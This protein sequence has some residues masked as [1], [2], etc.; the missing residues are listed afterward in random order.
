MQWYETEWEQAE[1]LRADI[2]AR[3]AA[4]PETKRNDKP[5]PDAWSPLQ[6]VAHIILAERFINDYAKP[7][8]IAPDTPVAWWQPV[9]IRT[10]NGALGAGIALPAPEMMLPGDEPA[11]L[12][13]QG[14]EWSA[15]RDRF[16]AMLAAS[17]PDRVTGAHPI[18]GPI[19]AAQ[20]LSM[21]NAH[22]AYHIK[23]FPGTGAG[24]RR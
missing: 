3:V 2:I 12:P 5:A 14:R 10:L 6:I 8:G 19:T 20:M 16:H 9:V 4:R 15:E 22:L 11:K 7:D 21:M 18:F 1:A 13:A 24:V 17:P 23:R